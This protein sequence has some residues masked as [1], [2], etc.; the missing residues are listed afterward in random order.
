MCLKI[1]NTTTWIYE[2]EEFRASLL[3]VGREMIRSAK[4]SYK[5]ET[6]A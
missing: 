5:V 6:N 4:Y 3:L 2:R 1:V